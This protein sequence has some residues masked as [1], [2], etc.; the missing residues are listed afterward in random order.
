MSGSTIF[1][2]YNFLL[3]LYSI[4]YNFSG[5]LVLYKY[6]SIILLYQQAI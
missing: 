5:L 6:N 4:L 3:M 2:L 1:T